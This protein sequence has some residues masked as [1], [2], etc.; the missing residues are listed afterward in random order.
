[1]ERGPADGRSGDE[2]R[3]QDCCRCEHA[4]PSDADK[5]VFDNGNRLFSGKLPGNRPARLFG[6]VAQ[7]FLQPQVVDF[8]HQAVYLKIQLAAFTSPASAV[9][10]D[11]LDILKYPLLP[12][13]VETGPSQFLQH[14][15]MAVHRQRLSLAQCI[16]KEI[17][18]P[19]RR[20]FRI[21]LPQ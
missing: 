17:Q 11:R 13:G 7:F 15:G 19:S 4:G 18:R 3:S 16:S 6:R 5:N 2:N 9:V 21:E 14:L 10:D 8:D 1:M 12:V 20:D